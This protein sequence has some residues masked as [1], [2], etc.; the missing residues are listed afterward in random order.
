VIQAF[1]KA[2]SQKKKTVL[3]VGRDACGKC[4]YMKTQVFE[5]EKPAFYSRLLKYTGN[6]KGSK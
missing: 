5:S 1:L 3:F 4:R 2:T 6:D